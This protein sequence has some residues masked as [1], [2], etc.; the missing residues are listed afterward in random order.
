[1]TRVFDGLHQSMRLVL[2]FRYD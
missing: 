1:M 2:R